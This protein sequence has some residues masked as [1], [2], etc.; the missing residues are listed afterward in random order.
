MKRGTGNVPSMKKVQP[1]VGKPLRSAGF[2]I[3]ELMIVVSILGILLGIGVPSFTAIIRQNR[4]A[5]ETNELLSATAIARSEAVKRGSPVTLCAAATVD[6]N[7]CATADDQWSNGW[8]VFSDDVG[9]AGVI[10]TDANPLTLDDTIIQVWPAA[11]AQITV[12]NAT[13]RF[14]SY[15]GDGG[16]NLPPGTQTAFNVVPANCSGADAARSV[17]VFAAGRAGSARIACPG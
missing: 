9:A 14:V 17:T 1:S 16:T 6:L 4:L 5:A 2:T 15:R 11:A 12:R 8:I 10:D 13:S 7:S 3:L